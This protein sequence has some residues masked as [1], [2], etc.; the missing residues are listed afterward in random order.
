MVVTR[1]RK[2]KLARS[3]TG[4]ATMPLASAVLAGG[5]LAHAAAEP[6]QGMLE[7]VVV[8]AQK[9]AEDLQKV[10]I[11][12]QV[13]SA[14]KLS[15][16]QVASFDDYAKFLPSVSFRSYGP[17]QAQLFFRG[18][19]S[20]NGTTPLHAGFL[21]TSGLYLDDIPVTTV[22]G[23]LDL[24]IF[25][26]SRVEALAGP[27]GTLY[28]ASSLSGTMRIITN[29][30]DPS[31]FS[32]A[33]EVKGN[34]WGHGDPGGGIEGYVNI[35][36]NDH[37]AVRLVGYY[38]HEGGYISNVFRQDTFQRYSP[39]P[40]TSV[41]GAPDNCASSYCP[42]TVNNSSAV[43]SNYNSVDSYGG[44]AALKVDL[45]DQWSITPQLIAQH[46]ETKGDFGT[47]PKFGDLNV[48]D[49]FLPHN[50]DQWYQSALTVE[51][52]ISNWDLA[53]TGGYFERKVD[54]RVDYS[55][56][57]V[58]YDQLALPANSNYAYTRFA[59]SSGNLINPVQYT[60]NYDKYTK[61]SHELRLTSPA[62][63]RLRGIVG[64]FFQ[65]QTDDIP[66]SSIFRTCR[67]TTRWPGRRTSFTSRRWIAWT[68]TTQ[69]SA[70]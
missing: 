47:D 30:P 16:L 31:A 9:R 68:A 19:S 24:H 65:R 17:S 53:Y 22:A 40:N 8:T 70:K 5:G 57:T 1:S 66:P 3:R 55:Q 15:Q 49:Y 56:Y 20:S 7:E 12:L 69:L 62:E 42:I 36:L 59:D 14:E 6:D 13:L 27:Q 28:G 18:I 51:G 52:K 37:A 50:I 23:A 48:A 44:R 25:D 41:A 10:P 21:P 29:K 43:R 54:N 38:D 26:V 63:N 35:P 61:I 32:A 58:G 67:C 11:S 60:Q 2:R 34:K 46:Q 64:L 45:N 4:W 33:Y 39:T